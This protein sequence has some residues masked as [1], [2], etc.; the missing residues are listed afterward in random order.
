VQ[1]STCGHGTHAAHAFAVSY[2]L[3]NALLSTMQSV[4]RSL[5]SGRRGVDQVPEAM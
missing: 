4:S 2:A 5:C 1:W 3:G